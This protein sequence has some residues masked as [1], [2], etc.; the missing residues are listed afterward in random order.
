VI[1][2]HFDHAM[3]VHLAG[4]FLALGFL[5]QGAEAFEIVGMDCRKA[6]LGFFLGMFRKLEYILS[7]R[8]QSER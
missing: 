2:V 6:V 5:F 7:S 3:E 1:I 4:H 8:E